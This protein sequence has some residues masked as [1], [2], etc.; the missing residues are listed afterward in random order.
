METAAAMAGLQAVAS[1][2]SAAAETTVAGD[3]GPLLVHGPPRLGL[4]GGAAALVLPQPGPVG[5]VD[6]GPAMRLGLL[7][8]DARLLPLLPVSS[9]QLSLALPALALLSV[10]RLPRPLLPP[11]PGVRK[12]R[13]LVPERVTGLSLVLESVLPQEPLHF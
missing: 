6:P 7:G 11:L 13:L 3:S 4:L 2:R 12:L 9:L 5:L 10:Y 8:L 1:V